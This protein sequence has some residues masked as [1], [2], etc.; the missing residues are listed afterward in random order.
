MDAFRQLELDKMYRLGIRNETEEIEG[1][2]C[3]VSCLVVRSHS[4]EGRRIN[5]V[6]C[7]SDKP[8]RGHRKVVASLDTE[9]QRTY[10]NGRFSAYR[11]R[12]APLFA[13]V[14]CFPTGH[15]VVKV[16]ASG[17]VAKMWSCIRCSGGT[18]YSTPEDMPRD[19]SNRNINVLSGLAGRFRSVRCVECGAEQDCTAACGHC[20]NASRT[21]ENVKR[22]FL[23]RA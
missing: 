13:G 10:D 4:A 2:D 9:L 19:E 3:K 23:R 20:G 12:F 21:Y 5:C 18:V 14:S 6:R 15:T 17:T 1:T 16:T 11:K 8:A 22:A 7:G